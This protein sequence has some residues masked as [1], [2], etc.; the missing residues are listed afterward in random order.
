MSVNT[1]SIIEQKPAIST[2]FYICVNPQT[3]TVG[4]I[5][6]KRICRA[7]QNISLHGKLF[8]IVLLYKTFVDVYSRLNFLFIST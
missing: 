5:R 1:F 7:E 3:M 8:L 6:I 4:K 2:D